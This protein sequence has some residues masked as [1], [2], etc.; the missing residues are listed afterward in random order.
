ML[1]P[2]VAYLQVKGKLNAITIDECTGTGLVFQDLV[3]SCELVNSSGLQ[4][5]VT[6]LVP[7]VA[8]D[9][10][11]GIQVGPS[12]TVHH[13]AA[14]LDCVHLSRNDGTCWLSINWL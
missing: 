2:K 6:G 9:K 7:T 5:Q 11:D 10:C 12:S 8:V 14:H 13:L 1:H 3:A 4:V